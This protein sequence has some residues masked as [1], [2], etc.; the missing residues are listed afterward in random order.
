MYNEQTIQTLWNRAHIDY[1]LGELSI[2]SDNSNI[3]FVSKLL[4]KHSIDPSLYAR[5]MELQNI[6]H[7]NNIYLAHFSDSIK[8][9]QNT[10]KIF[11][12]AGCLVGSIYCTRVI[13]EKTSMHLSDLGT[14]LA[15]YEIPKSLNALSGKEEKPSECILFSIKSACINPMGINYLDLGDIHYEIFENLSY[16][17]SRQELNFLENELILRSQKTKNISR[18]IDSWGG[19]QKYHKYVL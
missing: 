7:Y 18:V 9:I 8:D 2:F 11:S 10:G 12:S 13:K 14:Y 6:A 16:L 5:S 1:S 3:A 4:K 19:G 15:N 17:L